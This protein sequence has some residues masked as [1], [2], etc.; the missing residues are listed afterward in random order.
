MAE[1]VPGDLLKSSKAD[2][3]ILLRPSANN[4]EQ[5]KW[6][7]RTNWLRFKP[8]SYTT[9]ILHTQKHIATLLNQTKFTTE[10]FYMYAY[11]S[12]GGVQI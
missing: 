4:G 7:R 3:P 11:Q 10:F 1:C 8:E 2:G 12:F 6:R 5:I 9:H